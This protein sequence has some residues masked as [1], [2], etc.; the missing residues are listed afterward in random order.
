M[1][2]DR[3]EDPGNLFDKRDCLL[4]NCGRIPAVCPTRKRACHILLQPKYQTI[5]FSRPAEGM[6]L[7]KILK[8]QN[9]SKSHPEALA[10][11]EECTKGGGSRRFKKGGRAPGATKLAVI[12]DIW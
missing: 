6:L 7:S 8:V 4:W 9:L 3:S 10:K 2:R 12:G 5:S 11:R 1:A